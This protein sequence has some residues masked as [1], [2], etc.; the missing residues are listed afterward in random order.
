MS[1]SL[2]ETERDWIYFRETCPAPDVEG[3]FEYLS[4]SMCEV[5]LRRK[6]DLI[7]MAINIF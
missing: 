6:G 3:Y 7:E 1:H 4:G 2:L 5:Y